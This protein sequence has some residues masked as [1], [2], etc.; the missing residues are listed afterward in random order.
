MSEAIT[1][2]QS[3]ISHLDEAESFSRNWRV[4]SPAAEKSEL[5]SLK[6]IFPAG[7]TVL[8]G[9]LGHTSIQITGEPLAGRAREARGRAVNHG[10][11]LAG[12]GLSSAAVSELGPQDKEAAG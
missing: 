4:S 5:R 10:A 1:D 2:D 8:K 6:R 11:R 3:S 9:R 7:S 12:L